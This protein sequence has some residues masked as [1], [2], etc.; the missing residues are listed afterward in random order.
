VRRDWEVLCHPASRDSFYFQ[1]HIGQTIAELDGFIERCAP[2]MVFVDIGAHFGLFT[3]MAIHYGGPSTLVYAVEPSPVPRRI[4][5][6][7]LRLAGVSSQVTLLDVAVGRS[8]AVLAMLTTGA[9]DWHML[10]GADGSRPDAT[11]VHQLTLRTLFSSML[12]PPT[13]VKMDIEGLEAEAIEGGLHALQTYHPLLF[14]EL[15]VK[16]LRRRGHD[17]E[18]TL[19][20]LRECGYTRF[21]VGGKSLTFREIIADDVARIVCSVD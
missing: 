12:R 20:L 2:G 15:H 6:E 18:R 14:L 21:E 17:P 10:I 13:H 7:N 3:L 19:A 9:K 11:H 16:I 5:R 1:S 4:F 8:D